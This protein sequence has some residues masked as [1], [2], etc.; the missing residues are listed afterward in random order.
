MRTLSRLV[1]NDFFTYNVF[2]LFHIKY[3][4]MPFKT[5]V[6]IFLKNKKK[7]MQK[8]MKEV[9]RRARRSERVKIREKVRTNCFQWI[10]G[11]NIQH[12]TQHILAHKKA[13]SHTFEHLKKKKNIEAKSNGTTQ[14]RT[15]MRFINSFMPCFYSTFLV[16]CALGERAAILVALV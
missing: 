8:M 10:P 5:E 7:N 9:H 6:C 11:W 1:F 15:S 14:S 13:H 3:F 16:Y 4:K 2:L 12:S